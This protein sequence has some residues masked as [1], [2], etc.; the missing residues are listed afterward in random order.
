M[1]TCA[2]D[3]NFLATDSLGAIDGVVA[4]LSEPKLTETSQGIVAMAYD[5]ADDGKRF[6][7]WFNRKKRGDLPKLSKGFSA[8]CFHGGK[9]EYWV[10]TGCQGYVDPPFAIGTGAQLAIGAMEH[11]ATAIEAVEVACRRDIN[12]GGKVQWVSL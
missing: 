9:C 7:E 8:L 5:D 12:S 4:T 3:G 1:T 10:R 2:Y 11:G 6:A